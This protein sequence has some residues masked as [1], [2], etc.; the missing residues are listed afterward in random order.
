[1]TT[2]M[3]LRADGI[4]AEPAVAN[5]TRVNFFAA[6]TAGSV[7]APAIWVPMTINGTAL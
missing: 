1:M 3:F 2:T 6:G 5:F 7:P 4:V